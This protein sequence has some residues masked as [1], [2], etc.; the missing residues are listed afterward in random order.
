VKR[1]FWIAVL[2]VVSIK[3]FAT[4][5]TLDLSVTGSS[6]S[7]TLNGKTNLPPKTLLAA[8][9]VNPIDQGGDGFKASAKAAVSANQTI[10]FGPFSKAGGRL[11]PGVYKVTVGTAMA[12]LQPQEVQPF[13][14]A[15][16]GSLTGSHVLTLEGTV[17]RMFWQTLQFNINPDGSI[18]IPAPNNP[19]P[20]AAGEVWQKVQGT[21]PEVYVMTNGAY[22]QPG[23]C[24]AKM[25]RTYLVSNLPESDIVGAPQSVE[26]EIEGDCETGHY[27]QISSVFFAG[28]NRS[29]TPSEVITEPEVVVRK[30]IPGS[31]FEKA[32]NM[33]CEIAKEQ[34]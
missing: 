4:D 6:Q 25:F 1:V 33:L 28:K 16:G 27:N 20:N 5:I 7:L 30:V 26:T 15:H 3:A 21:D 2:S 23:C 18:G 13:F 17:E 10:Q 11:S 24:S 8:N 19:R 32:F 29:G 31:L 12:A 9:L 34:K 22:N 14:G